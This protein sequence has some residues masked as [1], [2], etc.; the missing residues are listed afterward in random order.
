MAG[1]ISRPREAVAWARNF[2]KLVLYVPGNHEFYGSSIDGALEELQHLSTGTQIQVLD[3]REIVL[4][5]CGFW[6]PPCGLTS[7]F[8]TTRSSAVRR[9]PRRSA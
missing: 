3:N 5:G 9:R 1:D 2:D 6:A 7:S 8:S 4:G